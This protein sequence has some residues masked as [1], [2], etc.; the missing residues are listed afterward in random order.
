M[1]LRELIRDLASARLIG[2]GGDDV[3]VRAVRDDSRRV[4]PGDLFVAVPGRTVDG[5]DFVAAA[6]GRGAVAVVVERAV[7]AAGGAAQVVVPSAARALG[8]LAARA[9]G[10]PTD[11]MRMVGVTGTNGKTTTTYLIEHIL[12]AAG[13]RPAVVGTVSNRYAGKEVA[14][15]YT[16]PTALELQA[17]FRDMVEAGTTDVV[18]ETT[19]AAL[20]MERLAGIDFQVAAFTNLTQDHLD[21]H[22]T[23]DAYFE[24]K[25]RLFAERLAPGGT[26]VAMVDDPRGA[27]ILARAPAGARRIRVSTRRG[28]DDAEVA[29]TRAET[30][31]AGV[32]AWLR[33]PRGPL[34]IASAALLG[35]YNLANLALAVGIAEALEVPHDAIARGIAELPGVPG[36]VQRVPNAWGLDVFVDYAHTPDALERVIA[37]LRPLTRR[38]LI[39]AFGCGGDRDPG[40]RAIMGRIVGR[41]ADVA[42]VTSDNPRTED[43]KAILSMILSGM[44]DARARVTVDPDRRQAIAAAVREAHDHDGDVV[45]VA[46]KGHEDYQILGT[47]KIHF[48][49]REEVQAAVAALP[50]AITV[51]DVVAATG[52]EPRGPA[53]AG[54]ARVTIDGRT[55]RRGDLYV[56]IRGERFD[57]HDFCGQAAA[58]GATG[59]LVEREVAVPAGSTVFQVADARLAMG[60]LARRVRRKWG[61]R[62]V[63][64]TGSTGKTTTKQLIAAM[65]RG[66]TGD[67]DSVLAPEGSLNNETGV[68]L[69]LLGLRPHH[70]HAVVEMGMRG[71]GQI[72]YLAGIAEPD[73]AAV[74][75]AGV[76]HVGV[77]G[78][79]DAIAQG[80]SEIWARLPERGAAIYPHGDARL[81]ALA[82]ERAPAARKISFG[83]EEGATVRVLEVAPRGVDGSDAIIAIAGGAIAGGAIAGGPRLTLR[84][85][86]VGRHNVTNA[87]CALAVALALELDLA[88]AARGIAAARP[89]R[90]RSEVQ[91]IGGRNVLVDCYNANPASMRAALETLAELAGD[92]RGRARAVAVIGDMLELGASEDQEH[93]QVG[94]RIAA[95]GLGNL[96]TLGE[97]ARGAARA[98]AAGGVARVQVVNID[99][100]ERAGALLASWTA[101]GDF[102]LVKASRGM[103]LERVVDALRGVTG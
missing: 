81:A 61:R 85:P 80:K 41:D 62:L 87:A 78:S 84:V 14:T 56:A 10:R 5:H 53:P 36:R 50:P 54:F 86:L 67:A 25:A 2:G 74:V 6:V 27:E 12:R 42:V 35:E 37:A 52:A 20:A 45:L 64:V 100:A 73:V 7:A 94:M 70:R 43:P 23:M 31:I 59:F 51:E 71:L 60:Q 44:A 55:A 69:T 75:N 97:R 76:A 13:A 82:A 32:R 98:A 40:K 4:E 38:R 102:I 17:L 63:G 96:M 26:A 103:R 33:T 28:D 48:D 47:T 11:R 92:A 24:A 29:V 68:P 21:V 18:M 88:A 8:W 34:E 57:G 65:L 1:R 46:G 16:T 58:A 77:V 101:P 15:S 89:A 99:D 30:S 95:L 19:S 90:Q 3:E 66:A 91:V 49:D 79:A 93:E 39:V 22:G 83:E 72:D 9:A